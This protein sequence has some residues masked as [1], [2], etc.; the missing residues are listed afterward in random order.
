[1]VRLELTGL[2]RMAY[3]LMRYT[4]ICSHEI[5]IPVSIPLRRD[6]KLRDKETGLY[7]LHEE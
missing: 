4:W 7:V 1:M 5:T 2:P 3:C 6:G